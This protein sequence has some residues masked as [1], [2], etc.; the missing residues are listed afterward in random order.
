MSNDLIT[1]LSQNTSLTVDGLDED[2]LALQDWLQAHDALRGKIDLIQEENSPTLHCFD[3]ST[4]HEHGR[5]I[6]KTET[7]DEIVLVCLC[8]DV[9]TNALTIGIRT[10]LLNHSGLTITGQPGNIQSGKVVVADELLYIIEV[11]PRYIR[12]RDG[13]NQAPLLSGQVAIHCEIDL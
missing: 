2:T 11:T 1:L 13:G 12:W 9:G 8:C 6:V 10:G 4:V 5:T 7:T 3:G